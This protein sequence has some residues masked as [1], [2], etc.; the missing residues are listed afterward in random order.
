MVSNALV[1][2]GRRLL[3][4]DHARRVADLLRRPIRSGAYDEQLPAEHALA[5]EYAV[6]RNAIRDAFSLLRAEGLIER[7]PRVG[8]QV[9]RRKYEHGIGALRGLKET[10]RAHGE[11]RNEVRAVQE[12]ESPPE[13]ARRLALST[14]DRV[15]CIERLRF[16]DDLPASLDVTYL[17][18]DL[19]SAVLERDLESNDVFALIEEICGLPLGT[20]DLTVEAVTADPCTAATLQMPN[21]GALLLLERLTRLADGRPVDL[22]YVRMRGDRITMF[23][24]LAR[25]TKPYNEQEW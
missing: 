7:R 25:P 19:G 12:V 24:K 3:R 8:T 10:L 16:V 5:R 15:F 4:A 22:E 14:G 20:A 23:G 11:V 13:V 9:T 6:S 17:A 18:P 2:D 1:A 21:G